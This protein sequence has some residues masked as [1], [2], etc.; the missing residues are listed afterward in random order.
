[1]M[2]KNEKPK[3]FV[4]DDSPSIVIFL[5]NYLSGKF[6]VTSF[7]NASDAIDHMAAGELPD[8]VLTDYYMSS[9]KNGMDVI[10]ELKGIKDQLPIVVLSGSC[11]IM[12]KIECIAQGADDFVEKPFNPKELIARIERRLTKHAASISA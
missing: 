3:V 6:E 7:N 8:L 2:M 5:E 4:I 9:D 11:D 10:K 1:M 12:L